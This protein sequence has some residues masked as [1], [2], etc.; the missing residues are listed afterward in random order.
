MGLGIRT[1][2]FKFHLF[3]QKIDVITLYTAFL[4]T[5]FLFVLCFGCISSN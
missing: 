5:A 1:W 2:D 4:S 3:Y